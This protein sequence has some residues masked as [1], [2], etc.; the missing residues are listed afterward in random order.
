MVQGAKKLA[1]GRPGT[2]KASHSSQVK[3]ARKALKLK[4]Y[5]KK[6]TPLQ[7][8]KGKFRDEAL[9]DHALTKAI[10]KASEQKVAAKFVQG[11]GKLGLKEV[12]QAGKDLNKEKRRSMVKR[13]VGRVEEKLKILQA[14]KEMDGKAGV[15]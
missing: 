3:T 10:D 9:D 15:K 13:K 6:G 7:L 1:G 8:P 2:G 14:K 12:M 4:Q 5:A 11:G